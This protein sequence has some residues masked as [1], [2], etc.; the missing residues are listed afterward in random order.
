MPVHP[1]ASLLSSVATA[2]M[3]CAFTVPAHAQLSITPTRDAQTLVNK[4]VGAGITVQNATFTGGQT[5]DMLWGS[6]IGEP[7][8]TFANG[9]ESIRDGI[10]ITNGDVMAMMPPN[11]L[12]DATGVLAPI[13]Y[14]SPEPDALC[15]RVINNASLDIFDPVR[16]TVDF[17]VA[18][19]YDG[20]QIDY[21]F[22][23]E[24]YPEYVGDI[25]ADAFGFFVGPRNASENTY[26]NIGLDLA[27]QPININGPFF[28]GGSVVQNSAATQYDGTTPRLT[29]TIRLEPGQNY[30]MIIVICDA[31]DESL[32]SGVFLAA[33]AGC[34]GE[35]DGTYVCVEGKYGESC[36]GGGVVAPPDN[37]RPVVNN[38]VLN[39]TAGQTRVVDVLA[40]DV[41]PNGD[42]LK[43]KAISV[44]TE[45]S[46]TLIAEAEV[47]Y[48][49]GGNNGTFTM[50]AQV[51]DPYSACAVSLLTVNVTGG[52]GVVEPNPEPG[53]VEPSP[54]ANP[55]ASPEAN[56]EVVEPDPI[57][58]TPED[59][60]ADG[61][62]NDQELS[63]GTDPAV[64]DT[65]GD[66]LSDGQEVTTS[67]LDADSDDDGLAD[68]AEGAFGT[69]PMN[70]DSDG[71]GLPDGLEVG[72]ASGI[73]GGTTV[74]GKGFVGTDPAKFGPDLDP[75]TRTDP[76]KG[77]TD[78][79]GVTDGLED[80]NKNGRVDAGE[81]NPSVSEAGPGGGSSRPGC[82]GGAEGGALGLVA[83]ALG[84]LITRAASRARP[85]PITRRRYSGKH[86]PSGG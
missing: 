75:G 64:R 67:P 8:G 51:C 16:L 78:A 41:D 13:A 76:T 61:L 5:V 31:G 21:L 17:T 22:G 84:L 73:Q 38:D 15:Q 23:S 53:P 34:Q 79:D 46:A 66:G 29:S 74:G 77:D 6:V 45:G 49:A 42:A 60:D 2:L 63:L 14:V 7:A 10:V 28:S 68:G 24:E 47:S 65:D 54:E 1:H 48:T 44:P 4:L 86:A 37:A 19:G 9:P 80:T 50:Q 20:M 32:D 11:D 62:T 56:P 71:D 26:T 36:N 3:L 70:P 33:L 18:P 39:I 52:V 72:A 35:C 27:D 30:R 40:N 25:F 12:P 82:A 55:E 85:S 59:P 43:V 58:P 57:E 83:L 81:R 69:N